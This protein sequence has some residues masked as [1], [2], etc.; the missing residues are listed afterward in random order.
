[1]KTL[2]H[3]GTALAIAAAV[4]LIVAVAWADVPLLGFNG[5]DYWNPA[6]CYNAV[7]EVTEM[8]ATYL[9]YDYG[10]N[11]YTF[12]LSNM[13]V[14]TVDS[15]TYPGFKLITF[16]TGYFDVY[17]DPIAGGTAFDYGINPPNATAPSTFTDGTAIIGGD[18][19]GMTITW[20]TTT[21]AASLSGM[22][23]LNRGSQLANIP[24]D[25]RSGWT[26]A[27]LRGNTPG[28]PDGYNWQIDGHL[29]ITE[30]TPTRSS[31]WGQLKHQY[32]GGE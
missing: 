28:M 31:T 17:E 3:R 27:G 30:P 9:T 26:L 5:Y 8:N 6:N 1:M 29:S 12:Y 15:L 20:N 21:G 19:N 13:C 16:S 24:V 32:G 7:G 10:T 23:D 2:R 22:V 4:V 18:L 14:A 11:E 25:Q